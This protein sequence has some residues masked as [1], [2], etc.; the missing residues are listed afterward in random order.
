M[1]IRRFD[2]G[3]FFSGSGAG[4]ASTQ[5]STTRTELDPGGP[6]TSLMHGVMQK[7]LDLIN[8]EYQPYDVNQRFAPFNTDQQAAFQGVRNNQGAWAPYFNQAGNA[9]NA[10]QTGAAGVGG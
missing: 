3:G 4:T 7:G 5:T 10:A 2:G 1:S 9:F 8:R 6:Y